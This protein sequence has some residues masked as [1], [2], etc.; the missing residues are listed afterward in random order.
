MVYFNYVAHKP[1][2]LD[3]IITY[4]H[5][6]RVHCRLFLPSSKI[7]DCSYNCKKLFL[8]TL[9]HFE[10]QFRRKGISNPSVKIPS[11][12]FKSHVT[13]FLVSEILNWCSGFLNWTLRKGWVYRSTDLEG[14]R[15]TITMKRV[16]KMT[17]TRMAPLEGTRG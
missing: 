1:T 10:R 14:C 8:K 5:V 17:S 16:A 11:Q 13:S 15:P 6:Q 12:Y 4:L 3:W 9:R 2:M 7:N